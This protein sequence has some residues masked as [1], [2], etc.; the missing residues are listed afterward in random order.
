MNKFK[1]EKNFLK[2]L[3]TNKTTYAIMQSSNVSS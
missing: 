1:S 2:N 3:L